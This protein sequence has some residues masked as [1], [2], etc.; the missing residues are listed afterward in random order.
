MSPFLPFCV[1]HSKGFALAQWRSTGAVI[2]PHHYATS[3]FLVA[4]SGTP[5]GTA[6]K[7]L[8]IGTTFD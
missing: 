4:Q 5:I 3:L 7:Y 6:S 8:I 2:V 1:K